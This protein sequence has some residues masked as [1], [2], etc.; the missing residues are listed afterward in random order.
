MQFLGTLTTRFAT[1]ATTVDTFT[2]DHTQG[3]SCKIVLFVHTVTADSPTAAT[4]NGA[5]M[6]NSITQNFG[7][8]GRTFKAFT[9]QVPDSLAS[10]TY[11][12]TMTFPTTGRQNDSFV[13]EYDMMKNDFTSYTAS[14]A[15]FSASPVV[16]TYTTAANDSWIM[17]FARFNTGFKTFNGSSDGTYRNSGTSSRGWVDSGASEGAA[18]S[19]SINMTSGTAP[20]G[21][22]DYVILE[23]KRET[24]F[25]LALTETATATESRGR[26]DI[27]TIQEN[28]SFLDRAARTL[29]R[30]FT[31][32]TTFTDTVF[33][34]ASKLF[35][36]TTTITDTVRRLFTRRKLETVTATERISRSLTVRFR[37]FPIFHD[38]PLVSGIWI[39]RSIITTS[40]SN[41]SSPTSSWTK[42][43]KPTTTFTSVTG[44][45][46]PSWTPR[47]KPPTTWS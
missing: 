45:S 37:E 17:A 31:Q 6:T 47:T 9:Y 2:F 13:G 34:Q 38:S 44:S 43:T 7:G 23:L 16:F 22:Y 21:T 14:N 10:G 4:F 25:T 19:K 24:S 32:L 42:R 46:S 40:W 33:A 28:E 3:Y 30:A 1:V 29:S 26:S 36:D 11:T 41:G 8:S 39:P 20:A 15:T 18:G 5:A 35:R 12:I 27:R